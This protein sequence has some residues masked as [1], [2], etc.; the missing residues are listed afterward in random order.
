MRDAILAF[1]LWGSWAAYSNFASGFDK[2]LTIALSQGIASLL[3]T[4]VL[5]YL[6][7]SIFDFF[8]HP[9]AKLLLPTVFMVSLSSTSLYVIHRLLATPN[10]VQTI[11]PPIVVAALYCLYLTRR[12]WHEIQFKGTVNE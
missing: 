6:V 7:A 12:H 9:L 11:I 10:L 3:T 1:L 8:H 2:I 5:A 4:L